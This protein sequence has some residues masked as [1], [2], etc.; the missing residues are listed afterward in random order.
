LW[1]FGNPE[2]ID[3]PLRAGGQEGGVACRRQGPHTFSTVGAVR[4][5]PHRSC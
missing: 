2:G 4:E 1:Q 3:S 5:L